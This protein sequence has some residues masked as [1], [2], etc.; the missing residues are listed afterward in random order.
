MEKEFKI[1]DNVSETYN[2]TALKLSQNTAL[3]K[4]LSTILLFAHITTLL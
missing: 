2:S 4:H 1:Y 3:R